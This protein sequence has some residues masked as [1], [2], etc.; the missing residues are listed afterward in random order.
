MPVDNAASASMVAAVDWLTVLIL[1]RVGT[2]V[3]ILA[4]AG[5]GMSLLYGRVPA[6]KG[7]YIIF[8]CFMLFS[9]RAIALGLWGITLAQGDDPLR[10]AHLEQPSYVARAPD[11]VLLDP[12]AGASV[13]VRPPDG[14]YD[15]VPH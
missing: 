5:L 1:G 4:I 3:A 9:S 11:P 8:G 2:A 12:Y 15:L 7:A 14:A 6:R 13:P 10:V